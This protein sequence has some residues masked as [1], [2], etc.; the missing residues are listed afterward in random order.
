MAQLVNDDTGLKVPITVWNGGIPEIHTHATVLTV[1]RGHEVGVVESRTILC[2][3]DNGIILSSSTTEVVLL[4][5]SRNLI[6]TI[7]TKKAESECASRGKTRTN[8]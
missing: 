3:S 6:E 5:I 8:R 2:V 7:T 1:G 4:E